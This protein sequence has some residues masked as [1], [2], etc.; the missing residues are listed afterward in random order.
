MNI[1]INDVFVNETD[2]QISIFSDAVMY[3]YG[4]FETLRTYPK[5]K[6]IKLNDHILRLIDS[7]NKINLPI[8]Y[9]QN[10]IQEK[11]HK[12][13]QNS[14]F[15]IQRIKILAIPNALI[16]VSTKLNLDKNIYD[17]VSLMT[18][19]H[20]RSLPHLK[21]TSYLDCLYYYKN[22][23]EQGYY[24]ALFVDKKNYIYECT[25]SNIFWIK[26]NTLFTRKNDVLPGI[27]RDIIVE[28][29]ELSFEYKN[30]KLDE[31]LKANEIFI[32]NSVIG[33]VPVIQLDNN[34]FSNQSFKNTKNI[35]KDYNQLYS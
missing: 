6:T 30:G 22:A 26:N 13:I 20:N 7:A 23:V 4:V 16:I 25:R 24:D 14:E 12:V 28:I 31:L 9:N 32:T 19:I 21:T 2:A 11:V 29:S 10:E 8:A 18:V 15:E 3:G 1:L 5:K 33:L 17:G 34:I 27:T 35:L